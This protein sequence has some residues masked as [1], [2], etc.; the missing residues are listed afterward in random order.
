M[1]LTMHGSDSNRGSLMFDFQDLFRRQA[2]WQKSLRHL[3]WPEKIR[4]AAR[5]RESILKLRRLK[6]SPPDHADDPRSPLNRNPA[7]DK[8]RPE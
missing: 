8:T 3:P 6:A 4:M 1:G 5:L 7:T 2:E